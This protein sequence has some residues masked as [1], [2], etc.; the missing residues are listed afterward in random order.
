MA[1]QYRDPFGNIMS[2]IPASSMII[3]STRFH[4]EGL[5]SRMSSGEV[6]W[7]CSRT[8]FIFPQASRFEMTGAIVETPSIPWNKP[9]NTSLYK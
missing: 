4:V 9:Y 3:A 8:T 6:F 5:W 2:I 7:P 1:L